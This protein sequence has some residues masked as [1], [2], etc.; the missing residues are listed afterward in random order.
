[1]RWPSYNKGYHKIQSPIQT[2]LPTHKLQKEIIKTIESS[3]G[4]RYVELLNRCGCANGVLS[5]HIKKLETSHLITVAHVGNITRL[6]P[7]YISHEISS[8]M[9][10]VKSSASK[11]IIEHLLKNG[12]S[13]PTMLALSLEKTPSTASWHI[14]RL[15]RAQLLKRSTLSEKIARRQGRLKYGSKL[16]DLK[17]IDLIVHAIRYLND[18]F[19][20]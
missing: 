17:D 12:P 20:D 15:V 2:P 11:S 14:D 4:I 18:P 13:T 10:Y 16:Y 9:N 6:Y 1:L 19:N 8:T 7:S 3:P 5:Y